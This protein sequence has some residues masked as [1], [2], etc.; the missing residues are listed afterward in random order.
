MEKLRTLGKGVVDT[1]NVRGR[2]KS[3]HVEQ[4]ALSTIALFRQELTAFV[5]A[6]AEMSTDERLTEALRLESQLMTLLN[7][8]LITDADTRGGLIM[9]LGRS[10]LAV[11]TPTEIVAFN[12]ALRS[13]ITSYAEPQAADE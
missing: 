7:E 8:G 2:L 13:L 9:E 10:F 3:K 1:F 12:D 6:A 5:T 11:F 4:R